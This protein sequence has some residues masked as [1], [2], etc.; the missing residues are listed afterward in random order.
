MC[1]RDR[2]EVAALEAVLVGPDA[3]AA[4]PGDALPLALPDRLGVGVVPRVRG[5]P[6]A[7]DPVGVLEERHAVLVRGPPAVDLGDAGRG[8][9]VVDTDLHGRDRHAHDLVADA[10]PGAPVVVPRRRVGEL[11]VGRGGGLDLLDAARRL[12]D[13]VAALGLLS[14]LGLV[15]LLVDG[16]D[17]GGVREEVSELLAALRVVQVGDELFLLAVGQRLVLVQGLLGVRVAQLH[18][19]H[20]VLLVALGSGGGVVRGRRRRDGRHG[21]RRRRDGSHADKALTGHLHGVTHFYCLRYV[22]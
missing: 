8:R 17:V 20:E 11:L 9:P 6:L 3:L 4:V 16:V 14:Q 7:D 21:Q 22:D 13:H 1:I 10:V 15:R 18:L 12:Q 5:D 19:G 2:L